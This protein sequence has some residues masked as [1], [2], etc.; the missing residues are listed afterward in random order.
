MTDQLLNERLDRF[1]PITLEEMGKVRLMNR[2]DTK[3]ITSMKTLYQLLSQ[4]DC[5][6]FIQEINKQRMNAYETIYLDTADSEMFITHHN[7][8]SK[9]EKV[10]IR[11][12]I[13]SNIRFLEIKKKNNK[14]RTS[15]KRMQLTKEDDYMKVATG[16]L[17][18]NCSFEAGTL[19]PHVET[20]YDRI[21]LVNFSKT[22][23]LTI[24]I[25]LEFKN[26]RTGILKSLPDFVILELKQ[27]T[28]K[29]SFARRLFTEYRLRPTGLSKYCIGSIITDSTLKRNLFKKKLVQIN[30]LSN[31]QYG[32][33]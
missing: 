18:P 33:I 13:D 24:D 21:T 14:G 31:Y 15:K 10:R 5:D 11:T 6:Y 25:N 9:R 1:S 22:E 3:Y 32:A 4:M 16:F 7:R 26:H 2:T 19:F 27:D 30:K 8:H 28:N 12:Y 23:R 17:N 20:V 29:D